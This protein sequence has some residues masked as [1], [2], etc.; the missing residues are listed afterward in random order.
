MIPH[1]LVEVPQWCEL[2]GA[3]WGRLIMVEGRDGTVVEGECAEGHTIICPA[4]QVTRSQLPPATR[5]P[6]PTELW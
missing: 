6:V 2:C 4:K 5:H 1:T 3:P